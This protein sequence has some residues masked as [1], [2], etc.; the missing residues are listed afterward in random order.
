MLPTLVLNNGTVT[1][2][3][4]SEDGLGGGLANPDFFGPGFVTLNHTDISGNTPDNCFPARN[5]HGLYRLEPKKA[6]NA[7]PPRARRRV[8]A[9]CPLICGISSSRKRGQPPLIAAMTSTRDCS[10]TGVSS[11][12]RSRFTYT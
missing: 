8:R 6:A 5:D 7:Q 12:A 3:A 1:G 11:F 4:V 9:G 2:N 10:A